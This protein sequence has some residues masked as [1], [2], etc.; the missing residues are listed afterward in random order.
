[1]GLKDLELRLTYDTSNSDL[2]KDFFVPLL[3]E[4]IAYDRGVGFFS[5]GWLRVTSEGM[6]A[7]AA[8]GGMARWVISPVLTAQ[9]WNALR[10]GQQ[11]REDQV[12]YKALERDLDQLAKDLHEDTLCALA[13]MVADRIVDFRIAIPRGTLDG[14]FH[15]KFGV[16]T[17][18]SGDRISF[19]GSYNDSVRGLRNYESIKVFP[20]WKPEFQEL[21][22]SDVE[23]FERLWANADPNVEVVEMPEATRNK[24]IRLRT[25]NRPYRLPAVR[26][27]HGGPTRVL[28]LSEPSSIVLRDY[29][30][31]AVDAWVSNEYRGFLE[32]ATGSGKTITAL[33]ASVR[34]YQQLNRLA[35]VIACPLQHLVKQW[36]DVSGLYGY[37]SVLAYQS[38]R[39]W[40]GRLN[41][42][43]LEYNS[44]DRPYLSVICTH[45]TFISA[46][47]QQAIATIR[48]PILLIADEAHHLGAEHGRARLPEGVSYRL[49]LSATP[50]RW[51]DETG[52]A[53]L[54]E[55]FGPT[56]YSFPLEKAIGVCLSPYYY[57]PHLVELTAEEVTRYK[58]LGSRIAATAGQDDEESEERRKMLLIRRAQILNNA[59]NKLA[60]LSE[61]VDKEKEVKW[62]LFYCSPGQIDEVSRLLGKEKGLVIH[63]FTNRETMKER[64]VLLRGFAEGRWQALVAMHCL[65]E[66]VDVPE[67]RTAYILASSGNPR[68]F[69]QRRGR[70]LRQAKDKEFATIHDL[71]AIPPVVARKGPETGALYDAERSMLRRELRRYKEFASCALNKYAALDVIWGIASHYGLLDI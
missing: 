5:S 71:V 42:A 61:L 39:L 6:V 14:D 30:R 66:G 25:E 26:Y 44:R 49:A 19:I 10:I 57:R 2:I 15:D 47:F 29:Q 48:G 38:Q 37:R 53:K 7:F 62:T 3:S 52:T 54:H 11:A 68:E 21:V 64:K 33:A 46:P 12:L 51:Y 22:L 9:D 27:R 4:S 67:T 65:D 8:N 41:E 36:D 24:L 34:L 35:V 28:T 1:M 31:E 20:S 58:E 23:R 13:W 45:K 56:V 50:D 43:I 60:M 63:N 55:Y 59:E 70:I 69:I 18:E 17:D 32:M 16:F 40:F